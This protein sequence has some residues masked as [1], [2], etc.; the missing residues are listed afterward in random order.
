MKLVQGLASLYTT[1]PALAII[2]RDA[3]LE[4]STLRLETNECIAVRQVGT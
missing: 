1:I 3:K 2:L 4:G